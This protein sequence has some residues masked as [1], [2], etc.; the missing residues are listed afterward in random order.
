MKYVKSIIA[1]AGPRRD[2]DKIK[3]DDK[4]DE[5]LKFSVHS[6]A[7]EF[8][9]MGAYEH[10]VEDENGNK[11]LSWDWQTFK[12]ENEDGALY[13]YMTKC[14]DAV[15]DYV[16]KRAEQLEKL[17]FQDIV[18]TIHGPKFGGKVFAVIGFVEYETVEPERKIVV[19]H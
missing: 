5:V 6:G 16:F 19:V 15:M 7:G 1:L 2:L 18:T 8:P 14:A 10:V 9:D 4:Y 17:C 11:K 13:P 3:L 12:S